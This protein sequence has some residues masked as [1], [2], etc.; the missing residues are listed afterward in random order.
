MG[1]ISRKIGAVLYYGFAKHLPAS[2]SGIKIG[3]KALRG[4]CGKLMLLRCGKNVNIEKNALFS[5][6]VSLGGLFWYWH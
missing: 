4:F 6:K 3:Q 1:S 2:S 5:A